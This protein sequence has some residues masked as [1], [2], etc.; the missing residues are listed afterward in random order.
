MQSLED[1]TVRKSIEVATSAERAFRIFT[2]EMHRWWPSC[3]RDAVARE[4]I[5]LEP[6]VGG[7]WYERTR[8]GEERHW[9]C[10]LAWNPPVS[11]LLGWQINLDN[12]FDPNLLTEVEVRFSTVGENRT[13]VDVEHRKLDRFGDRAPEAF[14]LYDGPHAWGGVLEALQA[15]AK[16]V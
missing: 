16:S 15:A 7:R 11:V 4:A 2:G 6:R 13:R 1:R 9:G 8:A 3:G 12:R 10:V 14:C 5:V